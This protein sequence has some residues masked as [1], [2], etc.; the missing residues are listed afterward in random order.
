MT[1][2]ETPTITSTAS[3]TLTTTAI[4]TTTDTPAPSS[5]LSSTPLA[6]PPLLVNG[7]FE[8]GNTGFLSGYTFSPGNITFGAT[9]DV[10]FNPLS[11]HPL[12]ASFGDHTNGLGL[13]L[14]VN[15]DG[16]P[17]TVVWSQTVPVTA[18]TE[19]AFSAWLAS[20]VPASPAQLQLLINGTPL[21]TFM[22]SSTAALWEQFTTTWNSGLS[23]S[24]TIEIINLNTELGGNDFAL[25]DLALRMLGCALATGSVID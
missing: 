20:W 6:C 4:P 11:A 9:Y 23:T 25:D 1:L 21:G 19:Y 24:A 18:S 3:A 10:L 15:G 14:A 22:A 2:T 12:A 8:A 17:G 5:T 13:M 16:S 7:D